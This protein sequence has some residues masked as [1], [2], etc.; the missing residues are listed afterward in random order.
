[1]FIPLQS[2]SPQV[3]KDRTRVHYQQFYNIFLYVTER[4]QLR[5]QH[6]Y[7]GER[8][9]RGLMLPY[10]KAEKIITSCRRL[11]AEHITFLGGEPTLH[12]DLPKMVD[13]AVELG[14]SQVMIDSNG[15][16]LNRIR[17]IPAQKLYYVSISLDGA[18]AE[19]HEKVRGRGTYEKT[20]QTIRKLIEEG[21]RVRI[22]CTIFRGNIQEAPALLALADEIGVNLVNFH[23]FSEEGNGIAHAD[24]SL[25]PQDWIAF[26]E[27]LEKVKHDYRTSIWYPP[28][29]ATRERIQHYVAEGFR[30][31]LGCSLDR[32]SIF[33]D[34]RCYVCSVLFDESVHFGIMTEE[35]LVLN[36]ENNEF[37]MFSRASFQA[38]APWLTGCPAEKV[39]E[40]HGKEQTPADL[41]SMCR[42]WKSQA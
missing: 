5:C 16:V 23:T 8:L 11:G 3:K 35:G 2:V 30:G 14:Y 18:T 6:C 20:V 21:Y 31:C 28:T 13:H 33:P 40:T 15:L 1:V 39:L 10:A 38:S 37:D 7:M 34:G 32:L 29:W 26:Y 17:K 27:S 22:N 4:C 9:N 36:R 42:C 41:I 25:T 19:T 24:W 12:P